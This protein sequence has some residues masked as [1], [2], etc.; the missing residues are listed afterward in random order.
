M[1]GMP[2]KAERAGFKFAKILILLCKSHVIA[3]RPLFC[4]VENSDNL[5]LWLM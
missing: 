3:F 2:L 4:K 1:E 5:L